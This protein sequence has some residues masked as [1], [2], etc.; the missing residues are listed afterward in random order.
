[1][2]HADYPK[3]RDEQCRPIANEKRKV[4][5]NTAVGLI[6]ETRANRRASSRRP[7]DLAR[8]ASENNNVA[9]ESGALNSI[10]DFPS[11]GSRIRGAEAEA[12]KAERDP[13]RAEAS[14]R[15]EQS[16]WRSTSRWRAWQESRARQLAVSLSLRGRSE[17]GGEERRDRGSSGD[18]G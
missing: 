15:L 12:A 9:C 10:A 1:M 11:V 7:I 4:A 6:G 8:Y 17:R 13:T 2:R 3:S 14:C 16:T 18:R 5:D